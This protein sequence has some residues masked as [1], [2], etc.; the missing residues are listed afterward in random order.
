MMKGH[1]NF[2]IHQLSLPMLQAHVLLHIIRS[3]NQKTLS[4]GKVQGNDPT[5][6]LPTAADL[7]SHIGESYK[8]V[9]AL[10]APF[11]SKAKEQVGEFVSG[12]YENYL[13]V[14]VLL[15]L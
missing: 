7:Q 11:K 6:F 13:H 14:Y 1:Y 3:S 2:F 8:M 5:V 12:I 15:F 4:T 9:S 10:Y